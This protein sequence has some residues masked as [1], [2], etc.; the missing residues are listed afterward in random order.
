M[1]N[2]VIVKNVDIYRLIG[3]GPSGHSVVMDSNYRN[4]TNSAVWPM[5]LMLHSLGG[6][7]GIDVL[8]IMNKMQV[9]Y[10]G[11]EIEITYKK[12]EE[13]PKVYTD[14]NLKYRMHAS[15]KDMAKIEKA[16]RL[17]QDKYCSVSAMLKKAGVNMTYEIELY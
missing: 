14:I 13:H 6:C 9:N 16:V 5:E 8:S 11:F 3:L 7:T 12:A 17:S 4:G 2:K 1:E 15:E 10:S